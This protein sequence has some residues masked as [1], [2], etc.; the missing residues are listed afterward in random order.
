M[1]RPLHNLEPSMR[2][3]AKAALVLVAVMFM[4]ACLVA[5]PIEPEPPD[6]N[7]PP[8]VD[9]D[10][11]QPE[12]SV[13]TVTTAD[14]INVQATE[15]YDPNPEESLS[16]VFLSEKSGVLRSSRSQPALDQE[17]LYLG[18]FYRF[19]GASYLFNPCNQD[20]RGEPTETI[21]LY[22][23]D[24]PFQ[25]ITDNEVVVEEGAFLDAW[26][27]VFQIPPGVCE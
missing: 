3:R 8:F 18:I 9:P 1:A 12:L 19:E 2:N 22:V 20:V 16:W 24:R 27:W 26:G 5:P 7:K 4:N 23:S 17:D 10:R 21:F 6:I 15:L 11:V 25:D 14:E 13:V